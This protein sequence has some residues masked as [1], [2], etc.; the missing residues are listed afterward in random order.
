MENDVSG[1]ASA[2][3]RG[4]VRPD[5]GHGVS[6]AVPELKQ[7]LG[8]RAIVLVG[9]MGAGK[10]TVGRRLAARLNLPFKD[11]DLEIE[12][13]AG[14]PVSDIFAIYGEAAF[15]DTERRVIA[16]LLRQGP[17]VLAT[18]GGA[19]MH[20]ETRDRI[21]ASG[22]SV[23][24]KADHETLMRRVRRRSNRPLLKTEDPDET[25]RRL[26]AERHPV[27]AEAEWTIESNDGSHDRVVQAVIDALR[28]AWSR[29]DETS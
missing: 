1:E 18:G 9:L 23:W 26:I 4:G 12:E 6:Q 21:R 16:R 14:M 22:L 7:R 5:Q 19:Y 2:A 20:P 8:S 10:T 27:Y 3:R 13:A 24:L 15:R 25:M 29:K 17:L 28:S 11:A